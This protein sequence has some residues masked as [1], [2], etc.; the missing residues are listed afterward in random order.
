MGIAGL[1]TGLVCVMYIF[2]WVNDEVSYNRFHENA[3]RIF[4]IHAYLEGGIK[5]VDFGG[6]PP[7]VAPALKEEY[8]EVENSCRYLPAEYF[9]YLIVYDGK[10]HKLKTGYADPSFFD[11]FPFPFVYGSK[12][13]P[14]D[15][16]QIVFT[17]TMAASIFGNADPVGKVVRFNNE[18]ELTVV[19]VTQ[20]I[21]N[22]SSIQFDAIIPINN[23]ASAYGRDN[24]L[25]TWYNNGF[26][27]FGLL[28]SPGG[29]NKVASTI[30]RRIQKE[31]PESTNYRRA[32]KFKD[33]YLYEQK[34]IRN[35]KIF[36]LIGIL[37]LV[38]ATLNFINLITARSGRQAKET[39]LRKSIGATRGNLV[40]LIYLEVAVLCLFA[41]VSAFIIA[42]VGL[43]LFSNVVEKKI[44]L[45]ALFSPAAIGA[46]IM[47]F[48]ITVFLAGSYPAFFLS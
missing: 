9:E 12:G 43:P 7:A 40:R 24:Y 26:K 32:Y 22:N 39:G 29:F 31:R 44:E 27:T 28:K 45:T 33:E 41:F 10:K 17:Q 18:K 1:V 6:C 2:F 14:N 16:N 20:D 11:I 34:H 38:A 25:S 37:V 35:I 4:V 46:L 21:P 5:K 30:T 3:D 8:P 42:L 36:S 48:I 47:V 23:L 13:E 19:G 15:P